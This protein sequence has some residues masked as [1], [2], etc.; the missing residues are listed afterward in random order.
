MSQTD[1]FAFLDI[2][3]PLCAWATYRGI[4]VCAPD[5]P[6]FVS[7]WSAGILAAGSAVRI[8]RELALEKVRFEEF[9]NRVS[10]LRGMFCFQDAGS[11]ERALEWDEDDKTHFKRQYL[12]EVSLGTVATR[13]DV[14]DSNWISCLGDQNDRR[15]MKSYWTGSPCPNRD[16]LWEV[17]V[18]GRIVVLGTELRKR[19]YHL[20]K[21]EF[22]DSLM[23][24]EIGRQAARVGSDLGSISSI[25][26][27]VDGELIIDYVLNMEDAE[28]HDFLRR[29]EQLKTSGHP[30]NWADMA[31]HIAN[32]AFG[33]L[34]DL[35]PYRS[36]I[37]LDDAVAYFAVQPGWQ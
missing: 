21:S 30:I 7:V 14:L 10:R 12:A 23:F 27:Q 34:P 1:A 35:R 28:C 24:L 13:R 22:P 5:K 6:G 33:A 8:G 32:D 19:A 20:L 16:P 25:I 11:A 18:D 2:D 15:W 9:P 4:L 37:S 31:P 29:L 17:L 36:R 3:K 26:R